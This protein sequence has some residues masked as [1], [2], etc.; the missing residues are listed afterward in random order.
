MILISW[1]VCFIYAKIFKWKRSLSSVSWIFPGF[2]EAVVGMMILES[3]LTA[4][5]QPVVLDCGFQWW[6]QKSAS[7]ADPGLVGMWLL[8]FHTTERVFGAKTF[9]DGLLCPWAAGKS[10]WPGVSYCRGSW[11]CSK[12][13]SFTYIL[14]LLL[15]VGYWRVPWTS[16]AFWGQ[17]FKEDFDQIWT[18]QI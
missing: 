16:T 2:S 10:L 11:N 4:L 12:N 5:R 3:K 14:F 1:D 7:S 6:S 17:L 13:L 9:W 15:A 18:G 8:E